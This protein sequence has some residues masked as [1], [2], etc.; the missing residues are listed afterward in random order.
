MENNGWFKI[1]L[2]VFFLLTLI[3]QNRSYGNIVSDTSEKKHSAPIKEVR[4]SSL[5]RLDWQTDNTKD[6]Q[7]LLDSYNGEPVHLIVDG[8]ALGF[9]RLHSNTHITIQKGFTWTVTKGCNRP[10][11]ETFEKSR[12]VGS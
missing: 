7:A 10:A 1:F 2:L 9:L 3:I 6:L 8:N 4:A 11:F 12:T 5:T